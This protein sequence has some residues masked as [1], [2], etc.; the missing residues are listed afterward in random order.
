MGLVLRLSNRVLLCRN[1]VT[2]VHKPNKPLSIFFSQVTKEIWR[3]MAGCLPP[4]VN[5]SLNGEVRV[6]GR[7]GGEGGDHIRVF[8]YQN[9][10]Y[11]YVHSLRGVSCLVNCYWCELRQPVKSRQM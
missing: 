6:T 10:V 2:E 3:F 5:M 9:S 1:K 4:Q 7:D 11:F 8:Y